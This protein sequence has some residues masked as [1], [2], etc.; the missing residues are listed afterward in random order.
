M[1]VM[2]GSNVTLPC[3]VQ[4]PYINSFTVEWIKHSESVIALPSGQFDLELIDVSLTQS[5]NYTCKVQTSID[6]PEEGA[7]ATART[8][9]LNV[10][11]L[12]SKL[13][14]VIL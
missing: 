1:T 6:Q 9:T 10:V 12:Y 14:F 5:G 11:E 4:R 8:I 3:R 13:I 2:E 7:D